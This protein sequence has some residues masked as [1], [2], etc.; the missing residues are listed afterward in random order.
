MH[1]FKAEI[2]VQTAS[3]STMKKGLY[4]TGWQDRN[5]VHMLHTFPTARTQTKRHLTVGA[6][7]IY[8]P[9]MIPY[10]TIVQTYNNYM[11]GTDGCD[12]LTSYY[13]TSVKKKEVAVQNHF[14]F[15][16]YRHG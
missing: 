7:K 8:T 3:G 14:S 5:P 13:K 4:F 11:G 16:A 12:Q 1:S 15:Y 9:T 2:S 10:P 6:E